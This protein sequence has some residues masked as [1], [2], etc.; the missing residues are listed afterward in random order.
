M[1]YRQGRR[2]FPKEF[3]L[4]WLFLLVMSDDRRKDVGRRYKGKVSVATDRK[5]GEDIGGRRGNCYKEKS[6]TRNKRRNRKE[7]M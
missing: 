1:N 6:R 2:Y 4:L 7:K 5:I 3:V